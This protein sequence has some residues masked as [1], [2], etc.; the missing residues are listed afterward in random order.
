[1]C[2]KWVL[3]DLEKQTLKYTSAKRVAHS[4][5]REERAEG[6]RERE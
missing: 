1:M 4:L 2:G 5:T 3:E 6:E